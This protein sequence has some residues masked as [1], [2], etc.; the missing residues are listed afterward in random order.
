[1]VVNCD[2]VGSAHMQKI[3]KALRGKGVI[4]MGKNTM[5]RKVIRGYLEQN[6]TLEALLPWVYGNIGFIFAKGDLSEIRKVVLA[7]KKEAAAKAGAIAPVDVWVRAGNTGLEPTQTSFLQAL[8]IPS[9]IN[10]GQVEIVADVHLIHEGSKV[11]SSEAALLQKLNIKPFQYGLR[12]QA[13]FDNGSVY[14][15]KL[16]DMSDDDLIAKFKKGVQNIA[17]ISLAIGHPTVASIPHSIIRGY[18]NVL[19]IAL[20]TE[21]TFPQA[22]KVKDILANPGKFAPAPAPAPTKEEAKP[23]KKE[24]KKKEEAPPEEEDLGFGLF[25]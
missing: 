17:A 21:F 10:K 14:D 5:M 18:K 24:E 2:N 4:M 15:P 25:D 23:A 20:T 16:L 13:V 8:N 1:M 3:R 6:P 7:E 22:Q 9:K 11:G 12:P 19:A